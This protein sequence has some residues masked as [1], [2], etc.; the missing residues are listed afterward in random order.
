M[1]ARLAIAV[2]V[3]RLRAG[4]AAM[5]A[6][7]NGLDAVVFSGGVGE[8]AP[9]LRA[10]VI[11]GLGFLGLTMDPTRN[12]TGEPDCEISG[13]GR[14]RAL[15]IAAREELEIARSVQEVLGELR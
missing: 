5:A 12:Q 11:G 7:A 3:H 13:P 15:V 6:A 2:Y 9:V 10:E 14:V 8:N 4:I 1:E